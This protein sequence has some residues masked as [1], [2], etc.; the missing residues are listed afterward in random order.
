MNLQ[1]KMEKEEAKP[2][3][4]DS[5]RLITFGNRGVSYLDQ[6]ARSGRRESRAF[7]TCPA[8]RGTG[9]R[10]TRRGTL[11][12][13]S[14]RD[15]STPGR[16]RDRSRAAARRASRPR[17]PRPSPQSPPPWRSRAATIG[18]ARLTQAGTPDS[19]HGN[20][21]KSFTLLYQFKLQCL[22]R[23]INTVILHRESILHLPQINI[24][25]DVTPVKSRKSCQPLI[26]AM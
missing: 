2:N 3:W 18:S 26:R 16:A 4:N 15:S 20:T 22:L 19:S 13:P 12:A 8:R 5:G 1:V 9:S 11:A 21:R 25:F 23:M 24:Y 14:R 17:T 7:R 6:G 10:D